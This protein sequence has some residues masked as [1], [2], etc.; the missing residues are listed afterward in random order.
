MWSLSRLRKGAAELTEVRVADRIQEMQ[1]SVGGRR[2][3]DF[4]LYV[5]IA[6]FIALLITWYAIHAARVGGPSSLPLKWL[7]FVGNSLIAFGYP[8]RMFKRFWKKGKFWLVLGGLGIA[9]LAV[10]IPLLMRVSDVPLVWYA[11]GAVAE[12]GLISGCLS[13]ALA[14]DR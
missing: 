14:S 2:A 5:A 8:M 12:A 1:R 10:G 13:W 7:G 11:V 3:F 6:V 4:L 9:H